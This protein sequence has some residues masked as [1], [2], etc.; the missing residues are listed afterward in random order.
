MKTT[1]QQGDPRELTLLDVN[2]RYMTHEQYARLVDNIRRDGVLTSVPLVWNDQS[3]LVVLSGNHRVKAAIEAG[4]PEIGWLQVDEPLTR[5]QQIAIQLSHNAITGQDDPATLKTLYD[6]LDD[7]DWRGYTGLDDRALELLDKVDVSSLSEAN[8][9]FTTVQLVFLP[10]EL[11]R[12]QQALDDAVK[13][14]AADQRWLNPLPQYEPVLDALETARGA[15][16]IGNTATAFSVI[17]DVFEAHLADLQAGW[18][19]DTGQ[20]RHDKWIP[21]ET[22][23]GSRN[24]PAD[25]AAVIAQATD[26]LQRQ[27][28]ITQPWRAL[29]MLAADYL[30][31]PDPE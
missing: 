13:T 2:A 6:E 31:I 10:G 29:E 5:Q 12:A 19:D 22:I 18:R 26:R 1:Y 3:R 28:G 16:A 20:P 25:A 14:A 15:Y 8:L 4:L 17:L 24:V 9:D 23:L 21:G 30:A 27:H 7:V 11:D